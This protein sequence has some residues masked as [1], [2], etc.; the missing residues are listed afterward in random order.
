M[1]S[2][3]VI[4]S[5]SLLA[6]RSMPV[7]PNLEP[8]ATPAT[9]YGLVPPPGCLC[10]S[11]CSLEYGFCSL[12]TGSWNSTV[13]P[14]ARRVDPVNSYVLCVDPVVARTL[15]NFSSYPGT[16]LPT[17][18]NLPCLGWDGSPDLNT[19]PCMYPDLTQAYAGAF[20]QNAFPARVPVT[21]RAN[22]FDTSSWAPLPV[23]F[24]AEAFAATVAAINQRGMF[25]FIEFRAGPFNSV[26]PPAAA[27]TWANHTFNPGNFSELAELYNFFGVPWGGTPGNDHLSPYIE[28]FSVPNIA[29]L[30]YT[31]RRG[32]PQ[33][34]LV[35]PSLFML[36]SS[37]AD[38][39]SGWNYVAH[40]LGHALGLLHTFQGLDTKGLLNAT[41]GACVPVAGNGWV[42]GDAIADTPPTGSYYY[43]TAVY[44]RPSAYNTTACT[45]A[46]NSSLFCTVLP[47]GHGNMLNLMSYD[48][49]SCRSSFTTLQ[50]ARMRCFLEQDMGATVVQGLGP[51]LVPLRAASSQG[52]GGAAAVA[53]EWLPPASEVW[54][55]SPAGCVESYLVQRRA[56][57]AGAGGAWAGIGA[58]QRPAPGAP[59]LRVWADQAP[60]ATAAQYSVIAVDVQGTWGSRYYIDGP[61]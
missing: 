53:L 26:A 40:E 1:L 6:V 46:F 49:M 37:L 11:P 29:S 9:L 28:V 32:N 48:E 38:L 22:V 19:S 15:L 55:P 33:G 30:G 42:T 25:P 45:L 52:G 7:P 8:L 18:W 56:V 10:P 31:L 54:C 17:Q 2:L 51:G 12:S 47:G 14:W 21:L 58:S 24:T 50:V 61:V 20:E 5:V 3:L 44:P 27:V 35:P 23:A 16:S 34:G 13:C 43:N 41:C 39:G 59:P 60:L 4:A 36:Q 57:Q